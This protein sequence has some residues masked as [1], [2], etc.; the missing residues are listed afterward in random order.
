MISKEKMSSNMSLTMA[1]INK[2][3]SVRATF[4]ISREGY[5]SLQWLQEHQGRSIKMLLS[6]A[7]TRLLPE[8]NEFSENM[9]PSDRVKKTIVL[10]K[11]ALDKLNSVSRQRKIP[12]DAIISYLIV[13]LK[14]VIEWSNEENKEKHKAAGTLIDDFWEKAN[15][16]EKELIKICGEDDPIVSRFGF[17]IVLLMNLSLAIDEELKN[18]T[19]IDADEM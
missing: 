2:E 19:P 16:A 9:L 1:A 3:R 11:V 14:S 18:G 6:S 7:I 15:Q 5:E 10:T 4:Q 17:V 13:I 12:R 8:L